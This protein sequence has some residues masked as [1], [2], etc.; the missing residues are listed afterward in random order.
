MA[1]FTQDFLDFFKELAA[2]NSKEWFDLNRVRYERSVKRPFSAFVQVLIDRLAQAREEFKDVTPSECIF[3]INRD[4]RFSK[5][6]SPYKLM[7]SAV[8]S[9][10]GKKSRGAHGIYFELNPEAVRVYGGLYEVDKD[11]LYNLR[12]G[13]A[14]NL[15]EF[16]SLLTEKK[17]LK[18][19]GRVLGEKNKILP[20]EFQEAGKLQPLLFNKQF[21][22]MT[23]YDS[24]LI[25]EDRLLDELVNCFEI[26]EPIELFFDKLI[27]RI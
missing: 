24:A 1:Y 19:F 12:E 21:Y 4:I 27:Q 25:L 2:N 22:F 5:D 3:R 11:D 17:F 26:S 7:C 16:N 23:E 15:E 9:P 8:V 6:K 13:L 10:G 14:N 18:L 20:K